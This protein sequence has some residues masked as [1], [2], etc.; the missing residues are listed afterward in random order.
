M[1]YRGLWKVRI[2]GILHLRENIVDV[3]LEV[4][5]VLCTRPEEIRA[6]GLVCGISSVR[7]GVLFSRGTCPIC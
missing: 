7:H 4:I 3:C 1:T 6:D 2:S 5:E